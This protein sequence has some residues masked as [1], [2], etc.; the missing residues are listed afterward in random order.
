MTS[1]REVIGRFLTDE[2][3]EPFLFADAILSALHE[4]GFAVVPVEPTQR[5]LDAWC[6]GNA[7][8]AG[9]DGAKADWAAM[10]QAA[11]EEG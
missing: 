6:E 11:K 10:L 4:A 2:E 9:E 3:C 8:S 7:L 5:I 1:A